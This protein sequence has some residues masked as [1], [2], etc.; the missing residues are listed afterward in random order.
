MKIAIFGDSISEGIGKRKYNYAD[1]IPT[2]LD[3]KGIEE[4][5]EIVNFAHTGTT[6]RYLYDLS[7]TIN[8]DFDY[9]VVAYG[10]VDGML[11]P[12]LMHK[13]NYFRYLPNRYKQNGMLNPRPYYSSRFFKSLFQHI[14]SLFRWN[15]NRLL[16][17]LQGTT[18]WISTSEFANKLDELIAMMKNS[19]ANVILVSTVKVS[20]KFFPGTNSSYEKFNEIIQRCASKN[21]CKY[22]DLYHMLDLKKDFYEDCFHPNIE[23]YK[24]IAELIVDNINF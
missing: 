21:N 23:G 11:R 2:Y 19:N 5:V 17:F 3:Q 15:L 8:F 6:I 24:C 14:D 10:N 4:S 9:I 22:V 20:D 7:N 1:L 18:T 16:L 13:P 12:D